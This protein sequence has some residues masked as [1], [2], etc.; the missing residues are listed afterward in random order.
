MKNKLDRFKKILAFGLSNTTIYVDVEKPFNP[1]LG[2]T[3]Q[4]HIR[5]C[6]IFAEQIS[7][8]PPITSILFQGRGYRVTGN[9]E[10]KVRVKM[11]SGEGSNDGYYTIRFDDG[12][13]VLFSTPAGQLSGLA[14]GD[15]RFNVRGSGLY[16]D[17]E[18]G[19]FCELSMENKGGMFS[20]K[21]QFGDQIDGQILKVKH[22]YIRKLKQITD[23]TKIPQL[24]QSDIIEK[25]G[26]VSGR[27]P[28]QLKIDGVTYYDVI[29]DVPDKMVHEIY[30]LPSNS[31]Y[32]EDLLYRKKN[33]LS[34]S[35]IQK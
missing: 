6:P 15:R 34:R 16:F 21:R 28:L 12:H 11:N 25:L 9:F 29:K 23:F 14:M 13:Q 22:D 18:N 35:Q 27:W 3:Y 4:G 19:Y 8:H 26:V 2:Q 17:E 33:D 24:S 31:N 7:H 20:K 10:G 32:R 5:G 30:P 1:I